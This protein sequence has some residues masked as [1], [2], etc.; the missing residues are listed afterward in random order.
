[1]NTNE[2]NAKDTIKSRHSY[3]LGLGF[4][5]LL[6][7]IGLTLHMISKGLDAES[8]TRPLIF[9]AVGELLLYCAFCYKKS[10]LLIGLGFMFIF[11]GI[12]F[13]LLD[14]RMFPMGL[15]ELW[16]VFVISTGLCFIPADLF[17][18]QRIRTIYLFPAV[19][20]ILLG[21]IFLLFSTHVFSLS[22]SAFISIFWPLVLVLAGIALIV[23]Y[24]I[25]QKATARFPYLEDD[26][27]HE[28]TL[29]EE[30]EGFF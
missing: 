13:S 15:K 29:E 18:N 22:F 9:F 19:M 8:V 1:M 30:Q 27:V 12:F 11:D 10:A 7:G 21:I 28:A 17:I 14:L 23:I 3:L 20:L 6:A 2:N 26:S 25:Q 16:P 24:V 5:M 4:A